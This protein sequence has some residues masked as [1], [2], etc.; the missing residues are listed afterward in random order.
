MVPETQNSL[1]KQHE[2]HDFSP[3]EFDTISLR[4]RGS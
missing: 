4:P 1:N 3:A 2:N